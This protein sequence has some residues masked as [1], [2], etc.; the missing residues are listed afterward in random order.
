M[1]TDKLYRDGL[2]SVESI[3][4]DVEWEMD[5][6]KRAWPLDRQYLFIYHTYRLIAAYRSAV[7]TI[8]RFEEKQSE[9]H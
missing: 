4:G 1:E 2:S 7:A 6:V 3:I 9:K 5:E 8:E